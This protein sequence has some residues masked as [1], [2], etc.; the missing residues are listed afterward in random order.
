[1][2]RKLLF[3]QYIIKPLFDLISFFSP[4]QD[5]FQVLDKSPPV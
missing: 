1:M 5:S 2:P 3:K 4:S